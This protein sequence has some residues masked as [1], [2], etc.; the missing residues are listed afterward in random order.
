MAIVILEEHNNSHDFA[1]I[2]D[3]EFNVTYPRDWFDPK[4]WCETASETG[5]C[6]SATVLET[7][8]VP[9]SSDDVVFP[10]GKSFFVNVDTGAN[11]TIKTIKI[12]GKVL[13]SK[14]VVQM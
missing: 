10:S 6:Q 5:S 7:E 14:I 2:S 11:I 3:I 4:N 8:R 1:N 12:T 13:F 9:C